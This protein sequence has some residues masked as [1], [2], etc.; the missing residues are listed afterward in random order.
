M[1]GLGYHLCLDWDIDFPQL[2]SAGS[3]ILARMDS[4][5]PGRP[6]VW[7]KRQF[8]GRCGQVMFEFFASPDGH[9]GLAHEFWGRDDAQPKQ[10][11]RCATCGARYR[12]RERLGTMGE[13]IERE[14]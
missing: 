12:L 10:M 11:I 9:F 6:L 2:N 1:N 5:G 7:R 4:E 8:C 14:R 3:A 13:A